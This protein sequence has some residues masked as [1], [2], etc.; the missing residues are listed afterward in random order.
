MKSIESIVE[1]EQPL[2]RL[3]GPSPLERH[4]GFIIKMNYDEVQV[5]TNDHWRQRVR[6]IP[7]NAILIAASFDPEKLSEE[8]EMSQFVLAMRVLGPASIQHESENI[9]AIIE[10]HQSK[11]SAEHAGALDGM[12]AYTHAHL[13]FSGLLCKVLG[14]FFQ[15]EDG[16]LAY[17]SDIE[18]Y[19]SVSSMRVFKPTGKALEAIANYCDPH[20]KE[21]ARLETLEMGFPNPPEPF[22]FGV[23]RYTSTNRLQK[24]DGTNVPVSFQTAD[25]MAK[26]CGIFGMTRTGKSNLVKTLAGSIAL[27][28]IKAGGKVGQ[29]I[30]DLNGEYANANEQDKGALSQVFEDNVVRYRTRKPEGDFF[31]LRPNFYRSFDIGLK[32]LRDAL[33]DDGSLSSADIKSFKEMELETERPTERSKQNRWDIK[34]SAYKCLLNAAGYEHTHRDD[35][36][37]FQIG[38]KTAAQAAEALQITQGTNEEDRARDF[39]AKY[40]NPKTGMTLDEGRTLFA[41]LRRAEYARRRESQE[42]IGLQSSNNNAWFDESVLTMINLMVGRNSKGTPIHGTNIIARYQNE[43]S[44]RGSPDPASEIHNH[45]S[46]GRLVIVDLSLSRPSERKNFMDRIAQKLFQLSLDIFTEAKRP[47]PI[48]IYIEEAHNMIGTKVDVDKPWPRI[49]KEGGK[50]NI[51]LVY[52]TQEPSSI[53]PNILANTENIMTSHLNNDIEVNA[54]TKYYDFKDFSN[55]IKNAQDVGF[56]RIKRLSAPF[57]MPVYV[58]KFEPDEMTRLYQEAPKPEGF[59]AAPKPESAQGR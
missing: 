15:D 43:H 3:C 50:T 35:Q 52:A 10:H 9:A 48:L 2:A 29:L 12:D 27:E 14:S 21:D 6:G 33:D 42:N 4:V 23:V 45:L 7:Q 18:D 55:S 8:P 30:L 13:Q 49:A 40:G 1:R 53:Q 47:P 46:D 58:H 16:N 34:V 17:G 25:L 28:S 39:V 22:E 11:T 44:V 56:V 57:V 31:D 20:R 54:L 51:G 32:T 38:K 59:E 5:L 37:E 24:Q 36:I 26:R 41:A 19:F